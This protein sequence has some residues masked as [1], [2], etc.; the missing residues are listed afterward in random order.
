ML[1]SPVN[2]LFLYCS[3]WFCR[4]VCVRGLSDCQFS[5]LD[6]HQLQPS[7]IFCIQF[8]A[9]SSNFNLSYVAAVVYTELLHFFWRSKPEAFEQFFF[10]ARNR[11]YKGSSFL[12]CSN[13]INWNYGELEWTRCMR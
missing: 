11:P 7:N 13:K 9:Y 3:L 5:S 6:F 4:R 12:F 1:C 2:P 10:R 8:V